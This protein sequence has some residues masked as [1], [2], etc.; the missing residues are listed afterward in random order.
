M[1]QSKKIF[2]L[3]R[4]CEIVTC[5]HIIANFWLTHWKTLT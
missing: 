5:L 2:W 1:I 4:G 3:I